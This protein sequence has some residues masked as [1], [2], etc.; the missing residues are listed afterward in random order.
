MKSIYVLKSP[1]EKTPFDD[2]DID[3]KTDIWLKS[4]KID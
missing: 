4:A 2:G 1:L 3:G